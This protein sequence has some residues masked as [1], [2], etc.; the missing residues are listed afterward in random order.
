M[1]AYRQKRKAPPGQKVGRAMGRAAGDGAPP[2]SVAI[3][4]QKA[5][6]VK[7]ED[8]NTGEVVVYLRPGEP[9]DVQIHAVFEEDARRLQPLALAARRLA[10]AMLEAP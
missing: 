7:P 10:A 6:P 2:R 8:T 9:V 3:I 5:Q 4:A 1:T